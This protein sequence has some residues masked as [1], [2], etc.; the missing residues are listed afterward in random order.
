MNVLITGGAGF[1]GSNFIRYLLH[2][3]N[4]YSIVNLDKLTDAG[5]PGNLTDVGRLTSYSFVQGDIRNRDLVH[6]LMKRFK[7]QI[8]I[9]FAVES[10]KGRENQDLEL[11]L[12]TNVLGTQ[13][14]LDA[15]VE[16]KVLKYIQISTDEVYG[17][18]MGR[19][20]VPEDSP[21]SPD[22]PFSASKASADLLVQSYHK[23]FGL[24]TNILRSSPNF[25]PYQAPEE[26]I[27]SMITEAIKGSRV[28]AQGNERLIRDWL[29]VADHVAAIDLVM[30]QGKS[31]HIYNISSRE[32][33][34]RAD[35][36]KIIVQVLEKPEDFIR[37]APNRKPQNRNSVDDLT[38]MER[39]LK[40]APS[41]SFKSGLI[42]TVL[43]YLNHENWW[44]S[45]NGRS[46]S[47]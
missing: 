20:P 13:V 40:W 29:H 45:F 28:P 33:V 27:P 4:I 46:G 3:Y 35:I 9:N 19:T 22:C 31:G 47:Y 14:L 2:K 5:N 26:M 16:H 30:Q 7:I 10:P 38:K 44:K 25:G 43:W 36:A 21:L 11:L 6:Y 42:Q 15:A 24:N 8:V 32:E 39:E 12:N 1:V 37:A 23:A 18:L 34:R 41:F 17:S